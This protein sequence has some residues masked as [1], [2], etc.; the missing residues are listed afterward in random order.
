MTD[1]RAFQLEHLENA[2]YKGALAKFSLEDFQKAGY[3]ATYYNNLKY[4]AF[5]EQSHVQLLSSAL[6]A[7][8]VTPVI[9]CQYSF[10]YTDV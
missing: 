2:F 7:A 5:D 3:S 4:I 1:A 8:G 9:P 10:P 6:T